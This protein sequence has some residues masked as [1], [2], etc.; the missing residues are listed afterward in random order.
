[1]PKLNPSFWLL[2]SLICLFANKPSA[3]ILREAGL[4]QAQYEKAVSQMD[5]FRN[6]EAIGLLEEIVQ[7]LHSREERTTAF[8]LNARLRLAEALEKDHQDEAAVEHLWQL[9]E[10]SRRTSQWKV[11]VHAHL[12]LARLHEK[13][14]RPEHCLKSL[15]A[16]RRAAAAHRLK[17]AYPRLAIR[18]ASYHRLFAQR[19]SA[20]F[21]ARE[22]VRTAPRYGQLEHE[23]TGHML[24]GMLLREKDFAEAAAHFADGAAVFKSYGNYHGLGFMHA[25][26]AK[27]HTNFGQPGRALLHSDSFR[28]AIHKAVANGHDSLE[29][30]PAYRKI[31][32]EAFEELGQPD[33]AIHYLRLAHEGELQYLSRKKQ[34]EVLEIEARYRD[35]QKAQTITKQAQ[36]LQYVRSKRNWGIGFAFGFFCFT[37]LLVYFYWQLRSAHR[38]M[39][40]QSAL[41]R[42][43][44]Q[45]LSNALKQQIMLQGEIHHRV[46]NNL[47]VIISLLDLQQDEIN[48]PKALRSLQSMSNRIYSMAAVHEILYCKERVETISLLE[49]TNTLCR[50][51][52]QIAPEDQE[53]HF[54]LNM[55]VQQLQL[56]TLMPLGIILNELLT[57][58]LKYAAMPGFPLRI[59]I[60]LQACGDG[61]CLYYRDNGRGFPE[62]GLAE[63][64][65]GLGSYLLQSMCRQLNGQ[66]K[67]FNEDGAVYQI[68]F[69][70]KRSP[71]AFQ[72]KWLKEKTI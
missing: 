24:L 43:A 26:L 8:G 35:E 22:V 50:H 47:Q 2:A 27:L 5:A 48:D 1:M 32:A 15:R 11:F 29:F 3:Q 28:L 21:Y 69:Q 51:I 46:K 4:L 60:E 42:E 16:A 37:L 38:K 34:N 54:D 45:D 39:Q 72:T 30:W 13:H 68:F 23:A 65:G 7:Q 56:E 31:R 14:Q 66:L 70:E 71:K 67:S 53:L 55:E 20:M 57:N 6:E 25:N 63:R 52:R 49:Y 19:D 41:I 64:E 58:S 61:F 12:S 40:Q 33:S 10:D 36:A 62:G 44:N 9:V 59:K 17:S 18:L